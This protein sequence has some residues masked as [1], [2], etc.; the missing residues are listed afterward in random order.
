MILFAELIKSHVV[1]GTLDPEL[2]AALVLHAESA[3]FSKGTELFETGDPARDFYM[4]LEGKV[5]L[6]V[7][8]SKFEKM[9]VTT[10]GKGDIVGWSW[11]FPPYEWH[12]DARAEE[13]LEVVR[14]SAGA[15]RRKCE[16]D[17]EFGYKLMK[18]FSQ[19]MLDRLTATRRQAF[20]AKV[21]S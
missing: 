5:S 7:S 15:M 2:R 18:C 6:T 8:Q 17:F 11:L 21:G 14:W 1:F 19:I 12:F 10:L 4:I 16:K 20:E 9:N 13:D 3:S